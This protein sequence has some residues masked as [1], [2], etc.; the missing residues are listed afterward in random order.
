MEKVPHRAGGQ[1]RVGRGRDRLLTETAALLSAECTV[2]GEG[3][4]EKLGKCR[5]V[6]CGFLTYH[7]AL[8]PRLHFV[9]HM[10]AVVCKSHSAQLL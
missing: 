3:T 7:G 9:T 5:T 2:W 1:D 8:V 10:A 4:V 6:G